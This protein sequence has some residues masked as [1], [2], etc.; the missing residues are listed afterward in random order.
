MGLLF[1]RTNIR[2][3]LKKQKAQTNSWRQ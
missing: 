3:R 1:T 2:K